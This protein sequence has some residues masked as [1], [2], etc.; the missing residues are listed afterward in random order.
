[1]LADLNQVINNG[2]QI[3][4]CAEKDITKLSLNLIKE[5]K[6]LCNWFKTVRGLEDESEILQVV[7]I[8]IDNFWYLKFEEIQFCFKRVKS[9]K[10]NIRVLDR[11][12][13]STIVGFI[14]EYD[15]GIRVTWSENKANIY[16]SLENK[17]GFIE[18]KDFDKEKF[19]SEGK[20][21][22]DE[23]NQKKKKASVGTPLPTQDQKR[24]QYELILPD[25]TPRELCDMLVEA[26]KDKNELLI[27][28]INKL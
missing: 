26:E 10:T 5:I 16:K 11:L 14:E 25:L 4:V 22:F 23:Q 13:G 15:S 9:G 6:E 1:M 2:V 20:K 8:I 21:Y 18:N 24:R 17:K 27:E 12:D 3:S 7:E 28:M 19:Y